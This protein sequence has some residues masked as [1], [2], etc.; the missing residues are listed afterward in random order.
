MLSD[1]DEHR[2]KG[3]VSN[4][5]IIKNIL[6]KE[7]TEIE[8]HFILHWGGCLMK[9]AKLNTWPLNKSEYTHF[10]LVTME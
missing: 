3:A 6:H 7:L 4:F 9:S 10:I 8:C 1:P 2:H 5:S